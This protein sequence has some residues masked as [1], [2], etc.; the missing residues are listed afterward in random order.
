[1]GFGYLS[2]TVSTPFMRCGVF[3]RPVERHVWLLMEV[4]AR[5]PVMQ[6]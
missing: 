3:N 2:T 1:M 6:A 5:P 4:E